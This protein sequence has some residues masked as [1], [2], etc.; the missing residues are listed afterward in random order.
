M[1]QQKKN[2]FFFYTFSTR[3]TFFIIAFF[4]TLN[5]EA[6]DGQKKVNR[7]DTRTHR[8]ADR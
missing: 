1:G 3:K 7:M 2:F 8:A 6:R 5:C 4:G